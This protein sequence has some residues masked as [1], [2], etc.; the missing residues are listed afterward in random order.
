MKFEKSLLH[1]KKAQAMV[2]FAIALPLLL[3]LLYGILETGRY[4]YLYSTVVTASRQAARYGSATG[5]GTTSNI[6]RYQ[7]CA[8][9]RTAANNVGF[10]GA[11]DAI[12]IQWDEGPQDTTPTTYCSGNPLPTTDTSLTSAMLSDNKHRVV[13]TVSKQFIPLVRL[14]PFT[15][16]NIEATSSRTILSSVSIV[17]T[18]PPQLIVQDPTNTVI[19]LDD[20]DPSGLGQQVTI[21]VTVTNAN[22]PSSTPTGTVDVDGGEPGV[23]CQITLANGSGSCVITYSTTGTKTITATYSGDDQHLA[24]TDTEGHTVTFAT[25]TTTITADTPDPSQVN[26]SVNVSVTVSSVWGTPTGTVSITG[27]NTNCTI[28]LTNGSGNCNVNFTSAGTK[29]LTATYNGDAE[30][31]SSSDTEPH[32]VLAERVTITTITADT[33]DPSEVGQSVSVNVSVIGLTT[34]TGTV[35]ITG[36][37]TNC[38]I[39]LSNGTGSCNVIFNTLGAKT[40]TA[41]YTGDTNHDPSSDT[42]AHTVALPSTVTTIT[43]DSP[44]PSLTGDTVNVSVTVTGGSTTP[45]GTV[46]ITGADGNCTISLTNGAGSCT[47]SF[48]SS[49]SRTLTATY[50]GDSQHAGSVDTETHTVTAEP[51]AGCT[52]SAI[53]PGKFTKSGSTMSITL[54]NN[55]AANLQVQDVFI[56]WNHDKGHQTGSDKTLRLQSARIGSMTFWTGNNI[57]A[58]LTIVPSPAAIITASGTSTITFTFHQSYDNWDNTEYISITLANPG[59]EQVTIT[60]NQH[61]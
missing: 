19:T 42:E 46:T 12:D 15:F 13:V 60:Q 11:F 20:P 26:G 43:D 57:G 14:V 27:A 36:A 1:N 33:P 7:D 17:V 53:V 41:N 2:E 50:A 34:P 55:L 8:G 31:L 39:T 47:V 30:H 10:L 3:L 37:D 32:N 23:S 48:I 58:S 40:L 54:T 21:N 16:N 6:P 18:V 61:Q 44:D 35:N 28:T 5:E 52:S 24:S 38:S 51:V 25:T 59:C 4:L 29:T 45:T 22:D 9:M 56:Q 49:G